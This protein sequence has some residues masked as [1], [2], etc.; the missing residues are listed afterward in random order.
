ME[1]LSRDI[2]I[3]FFR[4]FK[5]LFPVTI[6]LTI[7]SFYVWFERGDTK[8]GLDFTG[9]HEIVVRVP[10]EVKA[11]SIRT[12]LTQQG[13]EEPI[14]QEFEIGSNQY[15][16]R[17]GSTEPNPDKIK[18]LMLSAL[19]T[20][21]IQNVEILRNEYVGPTAGKELRQQALIAVIIGMLGILIY[22]T[23]RFEFA[24]AL[25]AI[26]ALFHDVVISVGVYLLLDF[27]LSVGTIAGILTII[28]YSMNDTIVIF[29]RVREELLKRRSYSL[30][31]II[32]QSINHMLSRTIITSGLTL[33]SALAL[34]FLGG[35]TIKDLT[36]FLVLGIICGTYSTVY[37]ASPVVLLWHK[38]RGGKLV[39]EG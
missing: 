18:T 26:I 23:I 37:I 29:D 17:I 14:V 25:G 31:E 32:N 28:G 5:F 24:F 12:A 20:G 19:T 22:I 15:S 6:L 21:G 38:Y 35:G 13:I 4:L 9:G 27:T 36:L 39:V 1:L 11:D 10:T 3:D 30:Q 2:N 33:V 16:I 7:L 8:W 34:F